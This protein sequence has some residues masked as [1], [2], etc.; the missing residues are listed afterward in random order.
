VD[1][2]KLTWPNALRA[3]DPKLAEAPPA[4]C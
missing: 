1:F 3:I 2:A 4:P